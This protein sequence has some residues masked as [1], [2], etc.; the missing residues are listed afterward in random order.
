MGQPPGCGAAP[1]GSLPL[2]VLVSRGATHLTAASTA[3]LPPNLS[4]SVSCFL[5]A[6]SLPPPCAA[7]AACGGRGGR[8]AVEPG[9][10]GAV[11]LT[12][13]QTGQVGWVHKGERR[14][15]PH[16]HLQVHSDL[17]QVVRPQEVR[18]DVQHLAAT[19]RSLR[20][21][22]CVH[23]E[24]EGVNRRIEHAPTACTA[25]RFAQGPHPRLLECLPW[26][27]SR[28]RRQAEH[29]DGSSKP[30]SDSRSDRL[31]Q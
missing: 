29:E 6:A 16:L 3:S 20:G 18:D 10:M 7:W 8:G 26:P 23:G 17:G 12:T 24:A 9:P 27:E 5:A 4:R 31:S 22:M 15:P 14:R 25:L 1:R 11:E 19:H 28:L 21:R 2:G 13:A 30:C